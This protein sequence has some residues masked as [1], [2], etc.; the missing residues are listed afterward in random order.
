MTVN[1]KVNLTIYDN[2]YYPIITVQDIDDIIN[3]CK[4]NK[5]DT[6]NFEFSS[7]I[8][9]NTMINIYYE[10]CKN[11]TVNDCIIFYPNDLGKPYIFEWYKNKQN[12]MINL[13]D[14]SSLKQDLS[15]NDNSLITYMIIDI[16]LCSNDQ[17]MIIRQNITINNNNSSNNGSSNKLTAG[18]IIGMI[19]ALL[20][21]IGLSGWWCFMRNSSGDGYRTLDE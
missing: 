1:I 12:E 2:D 14:N 11:S 10:P 13:P 15:I 3:P 19:C 20:L 6:K 17:N 8:T 4:S 5:G 9:P 16:K 18:A 21:I 7:S